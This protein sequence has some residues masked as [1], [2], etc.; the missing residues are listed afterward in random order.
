MKQLQRH[1]T[2]QEQSKK[3]LEIGLPADTADCF[4]INDGYTPNVRD[5]LYERNTGHKFP[6]SEEGFTPCWSVG[7]LMEIIDI[8]DTLDTSE[9]YPTTKQ[10]MDKR[11]MSYVEYMVGT[12]E[13]MTKL[14]E[15]DFSKLEE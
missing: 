4:Y 13:N 8:C 7:R 5:E 2:T 10:V 9:E 1:F 6:F 14:R 11:K 12:I 3:L 15:V